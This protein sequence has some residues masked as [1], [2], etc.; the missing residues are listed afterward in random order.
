MAWYLLSTEAFSFTSTVYPNYLNRCFSLLCFYFTR[1]RKHLIF[2]FSQYFITLSTPPPC[3]FS[4]THTTPFIAIAVHVI[5]IHRWMGSFFP[6]WGPY[7]VFHSYGGSEIFLI[8]ILY[9]RI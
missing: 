5:C 2:C 1:I 9:F 3:F 8:K 7:V 6:P 4:V